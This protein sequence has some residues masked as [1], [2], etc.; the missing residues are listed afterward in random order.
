MPRVRLV[1]G[2]ASE[3]TAL[4]ATL[5]AAGFEVEAKPLGTPAA[6]RALAANPPDAVVIDLTR[7]P[8]QGRDVAVALRVTKATRHLPL[9]FVE[10]DPEKVAGIR[11][12]LPD[13][14]YCGWRGICGALRRAIARPP[15]DPV[16]P[17]SRLAGYSGTPLPRKLGIVNGVQATLVGAPPAFEAT[18]GELPEGAAVRR[19][20]LASVTAGSAAETELRIWFVRRSAELRRGI[21]GMSART[22]PRGLW[23]CWPKQASGAASDVS[24][25]GVRA[26]GMGNGLVDYKVCAVDGV[27]SGLKFARRAAKEG[28]KRR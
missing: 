12:I 4:L 7:L 26:A 23:I 25:K 21:A 20:T 19:R 24:E 28:G 5:R 16:V 22:G 9:V 6:L 8:S 18:L 3:A 10:G 27:W 17:A 15:R 11:E 14:A 13:A 2:K 1:H